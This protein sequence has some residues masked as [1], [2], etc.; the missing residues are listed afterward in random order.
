MKPQS[1][2][3]EDSTGMPLFI[4]MSMV[5]QHTVGETLAETN[6]D[7]VKKDC[8]PSRY[9]LLLRFRKNCTQH[10]SNYIKIPSR[11]ALHTVE[12]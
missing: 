1:L 6:N 7:D 2:D 11:N 10:A 12:K 4:T 8:F 9:P 5:P 3:K